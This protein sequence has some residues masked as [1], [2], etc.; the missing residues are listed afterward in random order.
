MN[1]T[2]QESVVTSQQNIA[3]KFLLQ[4]VRPGLNIF[5]LQEIKSAFDAFDPAETGYIN[6][7]GT[8]KVI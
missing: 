2:R 5:Q 3:D 1:K 6:P 8:M 4:Y 7:K